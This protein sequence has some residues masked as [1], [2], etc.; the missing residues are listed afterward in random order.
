[1]KPLKRS[2]KAILLLIPFLFFVVVAGSAG[3]M[4][5]VDYTDIYAVL[6][7]VGIAG[8]SVFL[9]LIECFSKDYKLKYYFLGKNFKKQT[10]AYFETH[11]QHT[12]KEK[13]DII[14]SMKHE[15]R[16]HGNVTITLFCIT[17]TAN[18]LW[19]E[20]N[21]AF[22]YGYARDKEKIN[23]IIGNLY[24]QCETGGGFY[25]F[26][27]S[28]ASEPFDFEE[29]SSLI[30]NSPLFSKELK[31]LLVCDTH[32]KVFNAFNGEVIKYK[33]SALLEK[34]EKTDS[35][36]LFDFQTELFNL[37]EKL[38]VENYLYLKQKENLPDGTIKTFISKDKTKRVCIYFDKPTNTYK[39]NR[40]TFKFYDPDISPMH[41]EG[42]W[43]FGENSS[44]FASLELALNEIK[45]EVKDFD[46]LNL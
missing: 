8:Y 35:I 43:S 29:F 6:F 2:T 5:L 10:K 34:F 23:Y 24:L 20:D 32:K 7:F 15:Y 37:V 44:Y 30:K 25:R 26:F 46:E 3:V 27:E 16:R 39:I 18:K 31:K 4:L 17:S 36:L 12:K 21:Y 42:S 19:T 22:S 13:R 33:E 28:I 41:S 14:K 40:S 11:P 38:S 45:T 1:M 9:L